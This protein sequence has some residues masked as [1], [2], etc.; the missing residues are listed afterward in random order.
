MKNCDE[1]N[2]N[3][4]KSYGEKK[5]KFTTLTKNVSNENIMIKKIQLSKNKIILITKN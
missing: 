4:G 5:R 3:E 1:Q 2:T